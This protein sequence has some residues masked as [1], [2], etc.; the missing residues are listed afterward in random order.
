MKAL[1]LQ[2]QSPV[3]QFLKLESAGGIVLC[4][5]AAMALVLANSPLETL[6]TQF[7]D[8]PLAVRVGGF[9]IAKPLLLWVDDGLMAIF[10]MLV[11]LEVKRAVVEGE[12]SS[13]SNAALPVIAAIGQWPVRRSS[14]SPATGT[15]QRRC[16]A[17][18]SR[19]QRT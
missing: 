10:F 12:L 16:E 8:L 6:Y 18:P 7:L 5:A 11:G 14:T 19:W 2:P 15:T 17:G 13:L 9:T 4:A 3:Q 1:P